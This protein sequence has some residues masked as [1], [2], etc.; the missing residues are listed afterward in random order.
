DT[1]VEDVPGWDGGPPEEDPPVLVVKGQGVAMARLEEN[2]VI[3]R[4]PRAGPGKVKGKMVDVATQ[5]GVLA[6][7]IVDEDNWAGVTWLQGTE[8]LAIVE[9][10][11]G[12]ETQLAAVAL[13]P[14]SGETRIAAV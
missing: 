14:V 12:V 2:G 1:P 8:E 3:Y 9:T 5:Q 7:V 10:V 11:G 6:A 13:V 4:V